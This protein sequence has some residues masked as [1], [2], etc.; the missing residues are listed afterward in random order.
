[1]QADKSLRFAGSV[2]N[3]LGDDWTLLSLARKA[4]GREAQ[5]LANELVCRLRPKAYALAFRLL[6]NRA[7]AEDIVQESFFRLWK[8]SAVDNK[9]AQLSTYFQKIIINESMRVLVH[10]GRELTTEYESLTQIAEQQQYESQDFSAESDSWVS[11]SQSAALEHAISKL[12]D[13]QRAAIVLWAYTDASIKGIAEQLMIEEN[14]AHQLL[15]RAK[16]SLRKNL[17]VTV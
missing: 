10:R 4:S 7:Q 3:S 14:A 2:N 12:S 1:M 6:Q 8:S 5:H 13:R 11:P 17:G 15:H 9:D 16:Q